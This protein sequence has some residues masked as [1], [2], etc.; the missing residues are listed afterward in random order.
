MFV[1]VVGPEVARTESNVHVGSSA[2]RARA[3]ARPARRR[4]RAR[5][6]SA[7]RRAERAAQCPHRARRRSDRRDRRRDAGSRAGQARAAAGRRVPAAGA[8]AGRKQIGACLSGAGAGELVDLEERGARGAP[9]PTRSACCR[10]CACR[11]SCSRRR[12]ASVG[13]ARDELVVIARLDEPHQRTWSLVAYRLEGSRLVR[14]VDPEAAVRAV[15]GAD[16]GGSAPSCATSS[17]TS[18]WRAGR[19]RSRSAAARGAREASECAMSRWR[20]RKVR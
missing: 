7:A 1:A 6:R 12:S 13:D 15:R 9:A 2:R 18:S 5:A 4:P 20:G 11:G 8:R 17:S 19:T 10:P 14:T 3:R 16:A